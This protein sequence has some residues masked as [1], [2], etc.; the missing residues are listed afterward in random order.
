MAVI[1][2]V[3]LDFSSEAEANAMVAQ[4]G[5]SCSFYKVGSELF[6][7]AGP[8]FVRS[9]AAAGNRVFLDLKFHDIPNTVAGAVRTASALGVSIVTVHASGGIAMLR[10]AV[11]SAAEAG[12]DCEVFAVT[13][14]TSLDSAALGAATGREGVDVMREVERLAGIANAAQVNGVVCSGK[15]AHMIRM[16]HGTD[17]RLLI[18]GI[19]LAGDASGDQARTVTPQE[20][21]QAGANYIVVGRSVTRA[22]DPGAAMRAVVAALGQSV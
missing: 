2:I 1:P 13:V 10:A 5:D 16:K 14:L 8:R 19:R 18:P 21:A 9:L 15:E 6:T 17:L 20:A 12:G 3:A 4:L 7:A 22:A 11:E